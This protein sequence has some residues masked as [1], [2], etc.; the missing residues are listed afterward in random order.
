MSGR[1]DLGLL[2]H[3]QPVDLIKFGFIPEFVG[4]LPMVT[5]LAELTENQLVA[6]LTETKNALTKQYAKLVAMEG[7]ELEFSP[8][9]LHELAV[10]AITKG[11]G[12]RALRSLLERLMLDVMYD[13]P[14]SNDVVSV[15]ITRPVVVGESKPLIR[16]KE[17]QAAA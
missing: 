14:S 17:D 16:R 6:I 3:V 15:K 8:D 1:R 10:Q 7:V 5:V 13:L 4:R 2:E 12:A 9:A 11:T